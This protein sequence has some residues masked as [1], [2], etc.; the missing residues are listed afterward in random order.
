V[1]PL[2]LIGK[3]YR[4]GADFAK[5]GEG[6]CLSLARTVLESYGI[7]TPAPQRAWYRRLR[8]G[9]TAV[10][11]EELERWGVVTDAPRIGVA[12]LCQAGDGYGL[13][14]YAEGGWLSYVG[15]EVAWNPIGGLPVVALYCPQKLSCATALG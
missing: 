6:D 8:R 10:F 15:S 9:D 13:A 12:A 1:K 14:V 11:R 5:H 3:R 2:E 7:S 4:L